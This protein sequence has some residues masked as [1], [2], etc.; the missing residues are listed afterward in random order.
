MTGV[1]PSEYSAWVVFG[2]LFL[3]GSATYFTTIIV[4]NDNDN[5]DNN[6]NNNNK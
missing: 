3:L 6:N 4:P 1:I 2:V 5:N